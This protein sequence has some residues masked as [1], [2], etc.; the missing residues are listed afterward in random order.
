MNKK[1]VLLII[2]LL[3]FSLGLLLFLKLIPAKD[4]K[5]LV[6]YNDEVILEII[7]DEK[8]EVYKVDGYNGEVIIEKK[9]KKIRVNEEVSPLHICSKQGYISKSYE[10]IVCLPNKIVIK[11]VDNETI[12][13]VVR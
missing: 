11:I 5:A 10:S 9:N 3:I 7:L 13:T 2:F 6:Y 8:E 12:D 4:S 1:D